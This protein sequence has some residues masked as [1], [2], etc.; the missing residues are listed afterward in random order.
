VRRAR[1]IG[2][3]GEHRINVFYHEASSGKHGLRA[4]LFDLE[5]GVIDT[6]SASP[7]GVLFRPH[8]LVNQNAVAGN[9]WAKAHFTKA[10]TNYAVS[11]CS[12]AAM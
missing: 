5:P 9:N 7:L 3:D 12:V 1:N 2:G 4:V 6:V 10:G 11:P 8:H